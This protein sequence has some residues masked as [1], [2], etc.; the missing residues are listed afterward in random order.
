MRL[1]REGPFELNI[2]RLDVVFDHQ[3]EELCNAFGNR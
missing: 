1:L 3:S 2:L